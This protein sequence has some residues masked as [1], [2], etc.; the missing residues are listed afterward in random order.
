MQDFIELNTE[1]AKAVVGGVIRQGGPPPLVR[2]FERFIFEVIRD[3]GGG[4]PPMPMKA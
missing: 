3:L 1:E 4:K 2:A